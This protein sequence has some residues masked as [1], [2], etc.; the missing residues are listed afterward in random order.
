MQKHDPFLKQLASWLL[1]RAGSDMYNFHVVFP[2]KRACIFFRHYLSELTN[3]TMWAPQL[4]DINSFISSFSALKTSS[5]YDQL[6]DIHRI[7]SSILSEASFQPEPVDRFYPWG[8][9]ILQDFN[10]IDKNLVNAADLFKILEAVKEGETVVDYLDE[11]Q[12]KIIRQFWSNIASSSLSDHKKE[13]LRLW[14]IMPLLYERL[15][16]ELQ[17]NNLCYEGMIYREVAEKALSGTLADMEMKIV[18]AGFNYLNKAEESIF[19]YF[20]K[21]H[22]SFFFWDADDKFLNKEDFP[23]FKMIKRNKSIFPHPEDFNL[24]QSDDFSNVNISLTAVSLEAGQAKVTADALSKI[25]VNDLR[26]DD[27]AIILPA[28]YMLLP[29]LYSLPA[30]H[31]L[32]ISMGFPLKNTHI[33]AFILQISNLWKNA[34]ENADSKLFYRLTDIIPLIKHPL[35]ISI[36]PDECQELSPYLQSRSS[37]YL[38]SDI[39]EAYEG[40]YKLIFKGSP[41]RK[42]YLLALMELIKELYVQLKKNNDKKI[43]G[44]FLYAF[45]KEINRLRESMNARGLELTENMMV[46]LLREILSG[47]RLP[48]SGEPLAGIQLLGVLETRCLDFKHLFILSMNE[49]FWPQNSM[50]RSFI[51]YNL[52]KAY[53]LPTY[54]TDDTVYAYYFYRLLQRAENL[55]LLYNTETGQSA[56]GEVSR[57]VSQLKYDFGISMNE[58]LLAQDVKPMQAKEIVVEKDD[59]VMEKMMETYVKRPQP[60]IFSASALNSYMDCRLKFYL[61]YVAEIQ[62][63]EEVETELDSRHIGNILHEMMER[64]YGDIIKTKGSKLITAEDINKNKHKI[65]SLLSEVIEGQMSTEAADMTNEGKN[66]II[67]KVIEKYAH[68]ILDFDQKHT[69]FEIISLESKE[70]RLQHPLDIEVNGKKMRLFIGGKIDRLDQY[71]SCYRVI[72]YKTGSTDMDFIDVISL[73]ET[74]S[75]KRKKTVFQL[76][77]YSLL[78]K[79]KLGNSLPIQPAIY[80]PTKMFGEKFDWKVNVKGGSGGIEDVSSM[81]PEFEEHLQ[82][83]LTEI[84]DKDNAFTQ[85]TDTTTCQYCPYKSLCRK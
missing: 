24:Q 69:P 54:E 32:N 7:Y 79:T 25:I 38:P 44:E 71:N 1:H 77:F 16:V 23:V 39:F 52:R 28:E 82:V 55:H 40:I 31:V 67:K 46:A 49:G 59:V 33:S 12:L 85:T 57:Y 35:L 29:V 8:S 76:F 3:K 53:G 34:V 30:D 18:F 37:S 47:I 78:A 21:Q 66:L 14:K 42:D 60:R 20:Q 48:F 4:H 72:D 41:F 13:F 6:F 75:N 50:N 45:Y 62:E 73:F 26:S 22:Q 65:E 58:N 2:N 36:F 9:L 83:L 64:Y 19:K 63:A 68:V 80:A 27:I 51:P 43:E 15:R 5:S 56:S 70:E 17:N 81:L 10:E 61:Q 11:E 84:F 74:G